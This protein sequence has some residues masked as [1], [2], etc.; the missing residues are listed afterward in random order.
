MYIEWITP[1]SHSGYTDGNQY[2]ARGNQADLAPNGKLSSG[3]TLTPY[4]LDEL[5]SRQR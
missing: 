2:M 4:T 1:D 3:E 5:L